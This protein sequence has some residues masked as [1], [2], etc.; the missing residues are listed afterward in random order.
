MTHDNCHCGRN[1][2]R[3][4]Q[5]VGSGK[6][7]SGR[8]ARGSSVGNLSHSLIEDVE[9]FNASIP[10]LFTIWNLD[11]GIKRGEYLFFPFLTKKKEIVQR[12]NH[13]MKTVHHFIAPQLIR[14]NQ[15]QR[16][17][18]LPQGWASNSPQ[19]VKTCII[20]SPGVVTKA[21]SA[22]LQPFTCTDNKSRNCCGAAQHYPNISLS[23]KPS[24]V[25]V[26]PTHDEYRDRQRGDRSDCLNPSRPV[27]L[28][29]VVMVS[30]NN[31]I[32]NA[33]KY[34]KCDREVGIFHALAESC[35]KGIIA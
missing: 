17:F 12:V 11:V 6:A 8:V 20:A 3:G 21:C 16:T 5:L 9:R 22:L 18:A 2:C 24:G 4:Y 32:D 27:G 29:E 26:L 35:L 23:K 13:G 25:C 14:G 33:K 28:R 30:Q 1:A 19:G 15:L 34:Q 31:D 10:E 7:A